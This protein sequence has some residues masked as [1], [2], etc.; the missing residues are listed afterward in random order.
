MA[1][2]TKVDYEKLSS[3]FLD[4]Y[5]PRLGRT[6]NDVEIPQSDLLEELQEWVLDELA[7]SFLENGGFWTHEP[8]I[9]VEEMLYE[10]KSLVVVEGNRRL[11]ALL[12]LKKAFEGEPLSRKWEQIVAEYKFPSSL[13]ESIP[14]VRCDSRDDVAAY[15]GFRHVT[16]IKQW[17]TDEKAAYIS[18]LV[19]TGLSFLEVARKIGSKSPTVR[20]HYV[21]FSTLKQIEESVETFVP[22]LAER[23]FA[24]LYMSIDTVGAQQYLN[25]N[26]DSDPNALRLPIPKSH[27]NNL[28]NFA[29]WLFGTKEL[30]P[31]IKDTR[32]I[33][34]F[35]MILESHEALKYLESRDRPSF[36]VAVRISGGDELETIEYVN[37][38]ADSL[39]LALMRAHAFKGSSEL[40]KAVKRVGEDSLQLITLFP[41]LKSELLGSV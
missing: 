11:A 3:I 21:A 7:L 19:G 2:S 15:L 4:P 27:I 37:S 40:R 31:L 39:E 6:K 20:K 9:V 8:L 23:R 14:V 35:S 29:R 26:L 36:E 32:Q 30:E 5:N 12:S 33:S 22:E 1:I 16:G 41:D 18:K 10:R 17:N 28:K 24:V 38:A 25:I 13:F 34:K